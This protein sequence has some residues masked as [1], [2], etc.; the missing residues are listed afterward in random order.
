MRW[1]TA[2][3][4]E[5]GQRV[6]VV[7]V[8]VSS[9]GD[10]EHE[11]R[12]VDRV[13]ERLNGEFAGIARIETI[14]WQNS[15]YG[16]PADFQGR[17]P[18]AADCDV[19]IAIFWSRLGPELPPDF[20]RMPDGEPYPSAT[21]YE[22][23]TAIAARESK[24]APD[25]FVFRKNEPPRAAIDDDA[26]L[27]HAQTQWKHLR[28]FFERRIHNPQGHT[29]ASVRRFESA[30]QFEAQV[31][32][33]LRDWLETHVPHGRSMVWPIAI[34]GSPFRGL[35]CFD[36]EHAPVFFGRARDVERAMDRLLDRLKAASGRKCPFLLVVGPSGVGKSSLV[37]AGLVPRLTAPGVAAG[38]DA[39]RVALMRPGSRPIEALA[40]A[41]LARGS[42]AAA[43]GSTPTQA[44][45]ELADGEGDRKSKTPAELAA[46]LR[47][48]GEAAVNAVLRAL[49]R[50]GADEQARG[51]FERPL[52][53][54]LLLVVDPLDD[55]FGADVSAVDRAAFAGLLRALV[56]SERVWVVATL[57]AALYEPFL[58]EDDLE[59]LKES[60]ADY[61]LAPPDS[62]QLVEI[63]RKPAD[64]AG[65]VYET[66]AAGERLD[67]RLLR[68]AAGTDTLPPLQFILQRLFIERQI[69]G[70]ERRLTFAAL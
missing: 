25:V 2:L 22:V 64:A 13:A 57:R 53:A 27:E 32:A 61:N 23:L 47:G 15:F 49:A 31:D 52:R 58:R 19:V 3:E 54:D 39:W 62:A 17:I 11:R 20:P 36:V 1:I 33:L 37:R 12:R 16:A 68:D 48:G 21:A 63:V 59:A 7:R 45:P 34:K 50:I 6:R 26:E 29:V 69:S 9:P 10:V 60:G 51:G 55:L 30:D 38:V 66:N 8:F 18:E 46:A 65:L 42:P 44:L 5:E 28:T 41:L 35:A 14:R 43:D 70:P 40:E 56:A 4:K 67:E 24:D